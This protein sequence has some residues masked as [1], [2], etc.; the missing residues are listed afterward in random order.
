MYQVFSVMV[1]V[2][3]SYFYCLDDIF[4][5]DQECC[6]ISKILIFMY[7]IKIVGDSVVLVV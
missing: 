4:W 5:I 7:Y 3:C 6:M 2:F 1:D